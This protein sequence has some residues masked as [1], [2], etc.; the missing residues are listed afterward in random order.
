M[1]FGLVIRF[2]RFLSN[3]WLHTK[4]SVLSRVPWQPHSTV[5]LPLLSSS[6]PRRLA[7]ISH[8]I[9]VKV[10]VTLRPTFSRPV[11]LGVKH[12]LGAQEWIFITV[13]QLQACWCGTLSIVRGQ[14]CSFSI[15]WYSREHDVSETGFVSVLRWRWE[16]RH[17]LSWAP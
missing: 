1:G 11:Y 5:D 2:I 17:L 16:R 12:P 8:Q 15:I 9:K 3:S 10:K 6:R 4:T 14:V 13:R 7:A